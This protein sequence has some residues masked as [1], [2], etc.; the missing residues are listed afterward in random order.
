[1]G[2]GEDHSAPEMGVG[3]RVEPR[4]KGLIA[5]SSN[6]EEFRKVP[7]E[8]PQTPDL[9]LLSQ[10]QRAKYVIHC[11]PPGDAGAQALVSAYPVE[12]TAEGVC[13]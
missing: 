13:V 9:P 7:A 12:T 1:M 5:G 10:W 4:T 11:A 2:N 6:E 3:L 8:S